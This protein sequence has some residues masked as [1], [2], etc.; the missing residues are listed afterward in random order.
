MPTIQE[1]YRVSEK[2][3]LKIF[4]D[5]CESFVNSFG[6]EFLIM[7]CIAMSSCIID[8][9]K[10]N[11]KKLR[12]IDI[13]NATTKPLTGMTKVKCSICKKNVSVMVE[14]ADLIHICISCIKKEE[15]NAE[16]L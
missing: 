3:G 15:K 9:E 4:M 12:L 6:V 14:D 2:D 10:D 16:I 13:V 8:N 7:N 5:F 11:A 1:M